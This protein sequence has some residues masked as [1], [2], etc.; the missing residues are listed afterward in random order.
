MEVWL[1]GAGVP[2]CGEG[3]VRVAE[4]G[5]VVTL[6]GSGGGG[7][8]GRRGVGVYLAA[9]GGEDARDFVWVNISGF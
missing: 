7:G 6:I 1:G 4:V 5:E 9:E 3:A 8:P 2:G